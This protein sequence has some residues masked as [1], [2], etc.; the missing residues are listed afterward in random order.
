MR[1]E[2]IHI[3]I[4][5]IRIDKDKGRGM[6][7]LFKIGQ[8][9]FW[10]NHKTGNAVWDATSM[11]IEKDIVAFG[12][13]T[14]KDRWKNTRNDGSKYWRQYLSFQKQDT[15]IDYRFGNDEDRKKENKGD[16]LVL[17][18]GRNYD[19]RNLIDLNHVFGLKLRGARI[20]W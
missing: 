4:G 8:G 1:E 19:T 3:K 17:S 11:G 20:K 9:V 14:H 2:R 18:S 5:N 16:E 6:D 12:A 7:F 13:S 10:P 15:Q